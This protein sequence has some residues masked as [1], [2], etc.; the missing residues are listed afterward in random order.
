M[1][2]R[3]VLDVNVWV[4][5]YLS[6]ARGRPGSAAQNLVGCAFAGHCRL[7][8]VQ[9]VISH[10]MLDTLQGV[11]LRLALPGAIVDAA[12]AAVETACAEA[13]VPPVIVLGGGVQPLR[14][15]EDGGVLDTAI[16]GGAALLATHNL[17]DFAPGTRSDID[18]QT[19]RLDPRSRPD[20]LLLRQ[21]SLP[22]GLV[23]ASVVA[24]KSWLV[25]GQAPPPGVLAGFA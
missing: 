3:L 10:L 18:A 16:A 24:A 13:L 14:D 4:A 5:H 8:P 19:L 12:R 11:L 23:I 21:A 2:L 25:D 17:A 9:P 20:V 7:G 1:A 6:L 22:D 15:A